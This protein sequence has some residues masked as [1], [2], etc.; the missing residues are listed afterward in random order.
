MKQQ[1][2]NA[3]IS[4]NHIPGIQKIMNVESTSKTETFPNGGEQHMQETKM[5]C[6]LDLDK[7]VLKII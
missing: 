6:N 2:H 7:F 4:T 5:G 3:Q 1:Q